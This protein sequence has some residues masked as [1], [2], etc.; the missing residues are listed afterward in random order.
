MTRTDALPTDSVTTHDTTPSS[1]TW[2]TTR[3]TSGV[4]SVRTFPRDPWTG[5]VDV[6]TKQ[7]RT[8]REAKHTLEVQVAALRS[9]LKR[10]EKEMEGLP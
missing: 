2:V 7:E 5:K 10:I 8:V 9:F 4:I 6:P 3:K 1:G